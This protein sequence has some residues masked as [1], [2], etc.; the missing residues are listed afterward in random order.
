MRFRSSEV[1]ENLHARNA[2]VH[3]A[4][5]AGGGGLGAYGDDIHGSQGFY[6]A[7]AWQRFLNKQLG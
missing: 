3:R 1:V 7:R 5:V 6:S 2:R 4:F